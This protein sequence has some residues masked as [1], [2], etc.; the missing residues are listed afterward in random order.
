LLRCEL[1]IVSDEDVES[2][3]LILVPVPFE[4]RQS[5]DVQGGTRTQKIKTDDVFGGLKRW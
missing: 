2:V 5:L 1:V 3:I 4:Q